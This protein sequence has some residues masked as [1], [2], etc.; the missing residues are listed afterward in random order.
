MPLPWLLGTA[1][2]PYE[3]RQ[4]TAFVAWM[5]PHVF[6]AFFLERRVYGNEASTDSVQP[7][8]PS[9]APAAGAAGSLP[10]PLALV[11]F[12]LTSGI[13]LEKEGRGIHL[14]Q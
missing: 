10:S 9:P 6:V 14:S 12:P 5:S 2:L 11:S 3:K 8:A 13:S 4:F 1:P 7:P